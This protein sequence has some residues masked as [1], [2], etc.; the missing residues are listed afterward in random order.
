MS[1]TTIP[2]LSVVNAALREIGVFPDILP[3]DA[4]NTIKVRS[5]YP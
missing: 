2:E 4:Q 3:A 1:T 5:L